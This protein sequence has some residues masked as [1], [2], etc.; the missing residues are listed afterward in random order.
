MI[1]FDRKYLED[2]IYACW[3]GKNIGGTLGAPYE[4]TKEMLDVKGFQTNPGEALPNDDLD[5]QLVWLRA[6]D[7]LGPEAINA[8]VLGEYWTAWIGP[9]WNEYGVC[10]AHMKEGFLPPI[11]GEL[12]NKL[13]RNSNGAWIRTEIWA[14]L[15]PLYINEVIRLTYEDACVDHGC[16]EG[17]YAAIFIAALESAAFAIQDIFQ[18]IEIGLSKIPEDC[19]V[20][21]SVRLVLKE[22]EK[23][24][25][26]QEVRQ[27]LVRDSEDL[28]WFQAPANIGYVI[29]G[30]L[31]GECDFKKSMLLAVNCGDDTDCTAATVGAFLGIMKG[32]EGIPQDWVQYVGDEIQTACILFGHGLFPSTCTELTQ[33]I[34]N[35]LP[36]TMRTRN[37]KYYLFREYLKD[38]NQIEKYDWDQL[39]GMDVFCLGDRNDFSELDVEQLKGCEFAASLRKRKIYSIT[40]DSICASVLVEFE[41]EPFISPLGELRGT[42]SLTHKLLIPDCKHYHIRWIVPEGWSVRS[43]KNLYDGRGY[44]KDGEDSK[45]DFVICAGERVES[46]SRLILEIAPQGHFTPIYIPV[47]IGG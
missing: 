42:I 31:Y 9:N 33:S 41:R 22:Y 14:C 35:L 16:G 40:M 21:R 2:R 28:G 5:L 29:L 15:F 20:S 7:E 36:V 39:K 37:E 1:R 46:K 23:K 32:T 44:F 8:R 3:L 24:T 4:G 30:L 18:L 17:T 47:V 45:A 13:W 12:S 10:M 6:V 19:R 11:S 34:M 38:R 26:W 25:P 43:R 27:M